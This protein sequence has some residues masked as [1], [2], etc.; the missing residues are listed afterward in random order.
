VA[1]ISVWVMPLGGC[2]PTIISDLIGNGKRRNSKKKSNFGVRGLNFF[3]N[4]PICTLEV[5]FITGPGQGL[6]LAGDGVWRKIN[7][8]TLKPAL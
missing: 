8:T 1:E 7:W 6:K 4:W 3:C 2:L 5:L